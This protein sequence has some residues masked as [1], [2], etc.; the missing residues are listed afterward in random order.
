MNC[1]KNSGAIIIEGHVQGLSN[2]RSLGEKGIPVIVVDKTNCIARYSKY[3]QNF[4]LCP[5]FTTP[6]FIDFLIS[7]CKK[8]NL[9]GWA[10]FPSNDHAVLNISKNKKLLSKY[11]KIITEDYSIV[12]QVYNKGNLLKIAQKLGVPIPQTFYP[13]D[14]KLN[15]FNLKFPVIIK[16][17]EGLNFYHLF[18]TKAF[19]CN[20]LSEL[21]SIIIDINKR[22][23]LDM[24]FIQEIIPRN[25]QNFVCSFT[26]FSIKGQIEAFWTGEKLREHPQKFG[27]ATLSRSIP[28]NDTLTYSQKL[29]KELKYT[30][31]SEIEFILDPNDNKYKLIEFNARTWLWVGLAKNCGVDY[32]NIIY[33]FVNEDRID[34]PQNYDTGI[35]WI[36]P[37][38]DF[39]Y[40]V[41][42]IL[43]GELGM[44]NYLNS[45]ISKKLTNALFNSGDNRPGIA[46]LL[47]IFSYLKNR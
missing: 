27:T 38:S 41:L 8:Q 20:D 5:D 47:Q 19:V 30:G 18:H 6:D 4:F 24:V 37:F 28:V 44:F 9:S 2:T 21:K 35:Y 13:S 43:K 10:L 46:Y 14:N 1:N 16:G 3:C 7:L 23:N 25:K 29:L 33:S 42:S 32:A 17:L 11:F 34:F 22:I 12:S 31:V 45:I 26:S 15:R 36:N 39:A 40:S